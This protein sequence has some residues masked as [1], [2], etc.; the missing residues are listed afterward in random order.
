MIEYS[1]DEADNV[2]WALQQLDW[3]LAMTEGSRTMKMCG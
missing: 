2:D 1:A 3:T